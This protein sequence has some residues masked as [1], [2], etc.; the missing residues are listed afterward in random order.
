MTADEI[1][2]ALREAVRAVQVPGTLEDYDA[3]EMRFALTGAKCAT[4]KAAQANSF[5][6]S[7]TGALD[8]IV[9]LEDAEAEAKRA[10]AYWTRIQAELTRSAAQA[11]E[12]LRVALVACGDPGAAI[13]ESKHHRATLRANGAKSAEITDEKALP[14]DCFRTKRE[15]DKALIKARLNRG[16]D[17][18]GA[19]LVTAPPSLVI[20]SKEK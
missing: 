14:D 19:V 4:A 11:R 17:I 16:D 2:A 3:H 7:F 20:T 10:V 1:T 9:A 5:D 12:A 15:P 6:A 18:P 8:A 13:A